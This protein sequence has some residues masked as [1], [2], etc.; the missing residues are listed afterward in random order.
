[1]SRNV[2]PVRRWIVRYYRGGALVALVPV[3]AVNKEFARWAA[4]RKS[5]SLLDGLPLPI[6]ADNVTVALAPR[7]VLGVMVP[8]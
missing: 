7:R 3:L 2:P 6:A 4:H 8:A 1:M 5:N